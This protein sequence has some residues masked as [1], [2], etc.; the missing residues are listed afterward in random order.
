MIKTDQGIDTLGALKASGYQP[1]SIKKELRTN[2]IT[3]LKEKERVFDG[4]IGFDDTVLPDI[5]RAILSRHNILLLGLRGQAKTKIARLLVSLLDEWI[6]IVG[7]SELNDDPFQPISRY[8]RDLI[9][10]EWVT[11][12]RSSGYTAMIVTWKNWPLPM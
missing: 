10:G 11:I 8:A 9:A 5:E 12:R 3:K 7:G 6:P 2:L 1:R 4:I